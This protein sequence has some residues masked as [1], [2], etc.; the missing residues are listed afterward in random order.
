MGLISRVSSRTYRRTEAMVTKASPTVTREDQDKINTFA[1]KHQAMQEYK[2]EMDELKRQIQNIVDASDD[3][4]LHD[5][6]IDGKIPFQIGDL[7]VLQTAE[8]IEE[9]LDKEKAKAEARLQKLEDMKSDA[10]SVLG[11]LKQQLYGK[12]GQE[13]NLET[14]D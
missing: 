5:D 2:T 14:D 13:I 4:A 7:F 12:F 8:Q 3:I 11:Q 1:R 10:E 9:S 6:E